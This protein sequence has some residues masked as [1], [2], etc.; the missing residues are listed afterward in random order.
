MLNLDDDLYS[1]VRIEDIDEFNQIV[2][3]ERI[4][5]VASDGPS[6]YIRTTLNS[7]SNEEFE[8][9]ISYHLKTCERKD[10]LGAS[11]HNLDIVRVK[12]DE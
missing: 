12:E 8:E 7:L 1:M 5:I 6:D 3:L 4:K 11:A 2:N 9:F 10:L